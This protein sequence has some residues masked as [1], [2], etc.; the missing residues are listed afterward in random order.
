MR[1]VCSVILLFFVLT[2]VTPWTPVNAEEK[3]MSMQCHCRAGVNDGAKK[4]V[5]KL[6]PICI[7]WDKAIL[8]ATKPGKRPIS[9]TSCAHQCALLVSVDDYFHDPGWTCSSCVKRNVD[10]QVSAFMR[11]GPKGPW[12]V[13]ATVDASC[14]K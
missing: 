7:N 14:S 12:T 10:T 1:S 4:S 3:G 13:V 9:T 6:P 11:M 8:A 5:Q 2:S